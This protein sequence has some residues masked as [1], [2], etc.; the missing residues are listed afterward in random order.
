MLRCVEACCNNLGR[1]I[2]KHCKVQS[3]T[4]HAIYSY[5]HNILL[6]LLLGQVHRQVINALWVSCENRVWN[7]QVWTDISALIFNENKPNFDGWC[8]NTQKI[9]KLICF[10]NI[11]KK[12]IVKTAKNLLGVLSQGKSGVKKIV[13]KNGKHFRK[14]V[15]C[16]NTPKYWKNAF[17]V[18]K[19]KITNIFSMNLPAWSDANIYVFKSTFTF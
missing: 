6:N 14:C 17:K 8:I 11:L 7:G 1:W 16:D 12:N 19:I 4:W 3:N 10:P 2:T 5:N 13:F 18:W 15:F 9:D